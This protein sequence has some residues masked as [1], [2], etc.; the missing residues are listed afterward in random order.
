MSLAESS[1]DSLD[2]HLVPEG[3]VI[4]VQINLVLTAGEYVITI[5]EIIRNDSHVFGQSDVIIFRQHEGLLLMVDFGVE[6]IRQ[7][8]AN[9][10]IPFSVEDWNSG[11]HIGVRTRKTN[12]INGRCFRSSRFLHRLQNL[13][14]SKYKECFTR[15]WGSRYQNPFFCRQFVLVGIHGHSHISE[16]VCSVANKE[17]IIPIIS[18]IL[19]SLK[20]NLIA[21]TGA[22]NPGLR[23]IGA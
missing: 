11:V 15:R 4:S 19:I 13:Y 14:V 2:T 21:G 23:S 20:D 22:L 9:Q 5:R 3:K 18:K 17:E 6:L 12:L 8:I 10:R 1:I 7:I 16:S